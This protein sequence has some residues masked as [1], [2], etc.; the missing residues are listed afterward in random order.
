MPRAFRLPVVAAILLLAAS[1]AAAVVSGDIYGPG[2]TS[3][4]IAVV[5][6]KPGGDGAASALGQK[7]SAVLA[8]DLELSGYFKPIDARSFPERPDTMG[9]TADTTDF[10]GWGAT[11]AQDVV[12]GAVTVQGGQVIVEARMFDVPSRAE[13]G[14]VGR[15]FDG[16]AKDVPRM[17]HR[18]AD[19]ILE[20]L[21]G[22]RG[23]FDSA[24]VFT[25]T[26][27]GPLKDVYVFTF[28]GDAPVKLTDEKSIVV[29]PRWHPS[30]DEAL[31]VSYRDHIPRL[32]RLALGSRA[33]RAA[34]P[35]KVAILNGAWSPDGSKLLV[36]RDVGGNSDIYLL[37]SAGKPLRRL[38]DHWGVDVS[39]AWAPDGRRFAFCSSRGG[40][41]QIY[42]MNIDGTGLKRVSFHGSYNT[43]PS[44]SPKGDRIAY[45]TR[46]SGFQIAV[47]GADGT[48]GRYVTR[49][50]VNEDPSWAPDGR[51]LV[52][53]ARRGPQRVLV[54]TDREGRMQ[55]ELTA[56]RGDDTS[57]AWSPRRD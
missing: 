34:V 24:I 28:D 41:P 53:S 9:L 23:P 52:Y 5:P 22:E 10:D 37:D 7:F 11:G 19:A 46:Q 55:R 57:P 32:F 1:R 38:T 44:W 54:L 20:Y 16:T 17:A 42:V 2:S 47:T 12:K 43:S 50:G 33:V 35:G 18:M 26:R 25:S 3:I 13:V 4:P 21:T 39:P 14:A 51:Y 36:A 6:L 49:D 56:G 8:R 48:G 30:G 15:R 45:T 29:G 31:F 40:S 27:G